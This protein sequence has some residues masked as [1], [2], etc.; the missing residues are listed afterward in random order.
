MYIHV[1]Y[2]IDDLDGEHVLKQVKLSNRYAAGD[3]GYRVD[4]A[5][6]GPSNAQGFEA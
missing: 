1:L 6:S 3:Y 4:Q 2:Y 5:I